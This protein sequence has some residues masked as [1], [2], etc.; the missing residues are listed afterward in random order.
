M[1]IFMHRY[2]A[3]FHPLFDCASDSTIHDFITFALFVIN[4]LRL[5]MYINFAIPRRF[6]RAVSSLFKKTIGI[7]PML[8]A[9]EWEKPKV[10]RKARVTEKDKETQKKTPTEVLGKFM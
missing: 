1:Y 7:E 4:F 2:V 10:V 8:G 5:S 6:G 3:A 9:L